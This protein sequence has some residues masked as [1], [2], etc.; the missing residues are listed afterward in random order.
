MSTILF[1]LFFLL[2]GLGVVFAAMR[3]GRSGPLFNPQRR[4]GRRTVGLI[5]AFAVLVFGIGIPIAIATTTDT[6]GKAGPLD[7]TKQEE[8][9][10]EVFNDHCVQCHTLAA[11]HSVQTIGPNLDVL[12]PPKAL[13]LDAIAKGRARGQGQMPAQLVSGEEA[14]AVAAYVAKVAGRVNN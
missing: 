5:T 14:Q 13:V 4:G 12:R 11:S 1:V 10:R 3:S 2:L 8:A 7:L 6:A 9:G